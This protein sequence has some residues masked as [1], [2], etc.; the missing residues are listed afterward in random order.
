MGSY[1]DSGLGGLFD[2]T[3]GYFG[4]PLPSAIAGGTNFLDFI[5]VSVRLNAEASYDSNGEPVWTPKT[6]SIAIVSMFPNN[7]ADS[8]PIQLKIS[9]SRLDILAAPMTFDGQAFIFNYNDNADISMVVPENTS[10]VNFGDSVVYYPNENTTLT[11][12][13][14]PND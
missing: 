6:G 12:S 1:D 3:A 13:Y 7:A 8:D 14:T 11:H 9:V 4:Y 10:L 5:M 2:G